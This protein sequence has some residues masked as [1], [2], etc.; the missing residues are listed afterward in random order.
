MKNLSPAL[1]LH[2]AVFVA[3]LL[4][5]QITKYWARA[6]FSLPGGEPDYFDTIPVLGEWL[7]FRLVYNSGAAFG[8]QPQN[9]LPFLHPVVFF[10]VLSAAA[11]VL[12]AFYYRRLGPDEGPSRLGIALILSGAFGNLIDRLWMHKVTDFIDAGIPGVYPR[13]PVFNIADGAVSIGL[14]LLIF[15]PMFTRR[16]PVASPERDSS[17]PE[18]PNPPGIPPHAG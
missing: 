9:I 10:A 12:F 13:W 14:L 15:A 1:R 7:Q 17:P 5:D 16:K 4:L 11:I 2:A 18:A 8:L 3:G 6:R